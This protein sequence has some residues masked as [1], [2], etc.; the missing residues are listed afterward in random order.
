MS[1]RLIASG[2]GFCFGFRCD[3][4]CSRPEIIALL[5]PDGW[6]AMRTEQGDLL[7]RCMSCRFDLVIEPV[8]R[9]LGWEEAA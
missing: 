3:G 1:V 6:E 7:H 2:D 4:G 9:D 5:L 8:L